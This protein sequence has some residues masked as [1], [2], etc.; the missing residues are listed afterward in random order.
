LDDDLIRMKAL[1]EEGRTRA[2]QHRVELAD[3][4]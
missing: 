4:H 3:L 2:H 1:L